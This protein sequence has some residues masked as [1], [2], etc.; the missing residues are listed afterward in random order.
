VATEL[1]QAYVQIM[2]S[3]KGISGA[4]Q[5]AIAPEASAAGKSAGSTLGSTLVKTVTGVI[6]AAG[7]GKAFT[8]ALSEGAALQQS[9]GG[10]ETLFKDSAGKV[11]RYAEEAYKTT[12]LSANAYMESVTG[13]SA[14]L[15]QSL[16]GDT[17]KAAEVAHMAMVDMSD[18]ANK[19]GTS[20]DRIQD[21]YQGFAKQNYTMLD[22]LKLGYGGTKTEMERLL[23]DAEKLTGVKYDINNLSDVYQAIHAIQENLDITGTTAKEAA[24]TFSGSFAAMKAAAQNVLGD[25]ALGEDIEPSLIALAETTST[26]FF[27]NFIPMVVNILKG[28]PDLVGIALREGIS[29]IF[30]GEVAAQFEEGWQGLFSNLSV[31]IDFSGILTAIQPVIDGLK[32]AFGQLPALFQSVVSTVQPVITTLVNGFSRMDFSGIQSLIEAILPA[33]QAGFE[34]FVSIAGPAIDKVVQSFVALWNAAQPLISILA[35]AL[36]P[37]FQVLGSFLGGV[38]NGIMTGLTALFDG[39][40]LAI[41]FLTPVFNVLVQAFQTCSPILNVIAEG[42]GFVIGM[43]A[44]LGSVGE[45]LSGIMSSAWSNIQNVLQTAASIIDGAIS[46]IKTAFSGA[47][48]AA[49]VVKN[50]IDIAW[51]AIGDVINTVKGVISSAMSAAGGAFNS[52][53]SVVSS[54]SGTI[55]NIINGVKNTFNSLAHIDL[56][57]A[58]SAIMN[59]FL[60]GLKSAWKGVT[61]FVGGIA[62]WIRDH[63]GP[64]EYDKRLLIPA[65]KAIM[66]GLNEG[67]KNQF[68]SVQATVSGMAGE[69]YDS[70]GTVTFDTNFSDIDKASA[71]LTLSNNRLASQLNTDSGQDYDYKD[72]MDI[73]A[74]LAN[75]PTVVSVQAERQEI[76]KIYAEPVAE[77]Q[78]KRQAILNAVDGLGW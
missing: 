38:F 67:L 4:I 15:L 31:N 39:L 77:E 18:N 1:G 19:M 8:A 12:G 46:W 37:A 33:L 54:V 30:G 42:V 6:A 17:N 10:V 14:S 3:A 69:I 71:Q 66:N 51:M 52:F 34:Q 44:N 22:N 55:N 40:K 35:S 36:T 28:V 58:G 24:S 73:L 7:I 68:R 47:G 64:I 49:G 75:R 2:P 72:V 70:F 74:K 27:D 32:T 59:G 45:G 61:D 48:N 43:F 5:N 23:A 41:E 53:S 60:G 26:F 16:G 50:I 78:A 21:A 20:M 29:R 76:A 11:K 65:G 62:G 57:G 56:S 13:F 25:L 63:K 9:L